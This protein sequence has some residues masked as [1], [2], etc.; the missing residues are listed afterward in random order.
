LVT[1]KTSL[2][3]IQDG[4]TRGV[5]VLLCSAQFL[6]VLDVTIVAIAL[7][8]VRASLGFSP[9][10]LQW[11]VTAYTLAFGGLLIPGG[12]AADLAGRPRVFRAGLVLFAAASLGCGLAPSAAALVA[13]RVVQG[14]GAA[15]IAPAA[16]AL[17]SDAFPE[18]AAR[19][20]AVAWWTAA[21]AGGGASGWVL[22]GVLVGALG[23]RAVFLVNVPVCVAGVVLAPR[24]LR[25]RRTPAS[26]EAARLDLPGAGLVTV[27]LTLLVYGLTRVEAAGVGDAAAV[28]S[29]AGAALA[30]VAFALVERRAAHPILPPSALRRPAFAAACGAAV[31][32][33]ATT[34]PPMFVS[35]LYQQE[36][37][38][39]SALATGLW[40]APLNLAVIAGSLLGPRVG[41]R[42]TPGAVMAGGLCAVAAG[43]LVL[44]G[45][46]PAR[47]LPAF[48]LMGAGLGCA[49]VASTASGTAALPPASQ[50]VASGVLNAAAQV[51]TAV[52]LALLV[53][54]AAARTAALGAGED[55]LVG[56][57]RWACA[58]A[59]ALALAAAA[60][61]AV[62]AR[63]STRAAPRSARNDALGVP[64]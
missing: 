25:R 31:A 4:Q 17:L 11:V 29:L 14:V 22:G 56:G 5:L 42:W 41:A 18:P 43:A 15:M 48:V 23:W 49:A 16:L 45:L 3:G 37:L 10:E 33:T 47:L 55:A 21:A 27:G 35:V 59:A 28:G 63:R 24:V 19:R 26:R 52:G 40:C 8:D 13:L 57:Y 1:I 44:T 20:R 64:R 46:S 50:G 34:T 6:V 30:L 9:E 39:R 2:A 61:T 7:P 62:V 12:R 60:A 36:V 38:G 53:S 51:G 58:G 54:L 32:L